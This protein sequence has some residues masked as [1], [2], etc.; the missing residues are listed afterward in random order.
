VSQT[1]HITQPKQL[2]PQENKGVRLPLSFRAKR[3]H[4]F[5]HWPA[6]WEHTKTHGFLPALSELL[7]VPG[8]NGARRENI[9]SLVGPINMSAVIAGFTSSGGVYIN[10]NDGRLGPFRHYDT[11]YYEKV[12]GERHHVMPWQRATILGTGR[13][14]WNE[15]ESVK[16]LRDFKAHLRDAGIVPPMQELV[17]DDMV[18]KLTERRERIVERAGAA[19]DTRY[20]QDKLDTIDKKIEAINEEW[21]AY[22]ASINEAAPVQ[23]GGPTRAAVS[24]IDTNDGPPVKTTDPAAPAAKPQGLKVRKDDA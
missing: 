8:V 7:A 24:S 4:H 23:T 17:R 19:V 5:G 14:I 13:V 6:R 12:N 1:Q 3:P 11:H 15:A 10:P 22:S 20:Y 18:I 9:H 2:R 21:K 16:R